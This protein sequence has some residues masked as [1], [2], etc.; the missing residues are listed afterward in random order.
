M[1]VRGNY[2]MKKGGRPKETNISNNNK[3]AYEWLL[4]LFSPFLIKIVDFDIWNP[5][6]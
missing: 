1:F 5:L 2:I 6:K 4:L 3:K